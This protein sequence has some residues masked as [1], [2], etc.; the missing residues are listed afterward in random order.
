LVKE[1]HNFESIAEA[2][3]YQFNKIWY[4]VKNVLIIM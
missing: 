3:L 2:I 4:L 1:H